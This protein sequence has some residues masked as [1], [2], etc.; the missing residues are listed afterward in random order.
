MSSYK[1]RKLSTVFTKLYQEAGLMEHLHRSMRFVVLASV[2]NKIF[3]I[4]TTGTALTGYAG[5]LGITDLTYGF[6]TAI[7]F[8]AT[9]VQLPVSAL[10]SKTG[11]R[12]KYLVTF[13]LI[14][15]V[16]WILVGVVPLVVPMPYET[17]RIWSI[18]LL[19]GLGSVTA[20]FYPVCLQSWIADLVPLG[21]RGRWF[22]ARDRLIMVVNLVFSLGMASLLDRITGIEGYCIVFIVAGLIGVA[23]V[24]CFLAV[25]DVPMQRTKQPDFRRILT[26]TFQ[27]RYF[28]KFLIFWTLWLLSSYMSS[29]YTS[30]YA[31]YSI[32][33]S[34]MDLTVYGTILGG[35]MTILVLNLWGKMI[36]HRGNR[37]TMLVSGIGTALS[38]LILLFAREGQKGAYI[39]YSVVGAAF[40]EIPYLVAN[41][42]LLAYSPDAERPAYIAVFN[43]L[44]SVLGS[45]VGSMFGGLILQFV[46]SFLAACPIV[47]F[48]ETLNQYQFLFLLSALVRVA[49]LL[50]MVPGLKKDQ[51]V[52]R[53]LAQ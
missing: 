2:F 21:I 40:W 12:K 28:R 6:L 34:F 51:P 27:D 52:E 39:L 53:S 5:A 36:D 11:Q 46:P 50:V 38:T 42:M 18:L 48:G 4:V 14:S 1:K 20:A 26:S 13:G 19:M 37:F 10:L 43:G 7:P 16:F 35:V 8:L 15:K 49:I 24:L 23:D 22:C 3:T 29:P 41:N 9:L 33:M 47:L 17:L 44:T 31:L 25:E 45:F 30:Y 32:K